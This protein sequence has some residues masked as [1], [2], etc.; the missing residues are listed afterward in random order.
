M[1]ADVLVTFI[2]MVRLDLL[3]VDANG[4][5]AR[6]S[7]DN[8][9]DVVATELVHGHNTFLKQQITSSYTQTTLALSQSDQ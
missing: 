1:R 9:L 8:Y 4:H 6:N 3:V 5:W 7:T 2:G